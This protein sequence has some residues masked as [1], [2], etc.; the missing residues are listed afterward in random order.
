MGTPNSKAIVFSFDGTGNEPSD[1]GEFV[2]DESITNVL[3]LH[4]LLGGGMG[5]EGEVLGDGKGKQLAFYYNGIGT[6]EEGR[7]VPGL[8]RVISFVN[9]AFAPT[10]G[11]AKRILREARRDFEKS[12][13]T[14]DRVAV[15]GYSRGAALARKFVSQLLEDEKC[16]SVAFLGVF[17]TVAAMNGVLS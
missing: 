5:E 4:L 10:W 17:D 6:R 14:G 8:G 11:D 2:E 13:N 9:M 12:Y 3:K 7:S 15:F 16:G 1:A